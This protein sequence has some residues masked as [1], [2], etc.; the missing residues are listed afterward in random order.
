MGGKLS[1]LKSHIAAVKSNSLFEG[2]DFKLAASHHPLNDK[3]ASECGFT[4]LSVRI[5][6]VA[7]ATT[8]FIAVQL[9]SSVIVN[10]VLH[11]SWNAFL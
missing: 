6:K 1:S 7:A 8:I 9:A 4:S 10:F 2:T 3:V 5:V 11:F